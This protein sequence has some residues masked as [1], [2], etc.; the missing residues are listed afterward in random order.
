MM[1][2]ERGTD[3]PLRSR[4]RSARIHHSMNYGHSRKEPPVVSEVL[5]DIERDPGA[6]PAIRAAG[7][8]KTFGTIRAVDDVSFDL[9]PGRIYGL[10]GPNG[11]GKTTLI[12]LLTGMARPAAGTVEVLG[13]AMPSRPNLSRIGYMT[14][15]DGVYPA[16]TVGEN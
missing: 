7:L 16:L 14:Q 5:P 4:S 2:G 10:L 6:Q 8:V 3:G 12:R 11:S 15:S 1:T 13:V 9:A